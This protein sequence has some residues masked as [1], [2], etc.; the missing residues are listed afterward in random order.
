MLEGRS[1]GPGVALVLADRNKAVNVAMDLAHGITVDD[2]ARWARQAEERAAAEAAKPPCAKCK[3]AKGGQ[4]KT[5]KV[6][7]G[8]SYR[9]YERKGTQWDAGY[10]DGKNAALMGTATSVDATG[11]TELE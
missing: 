3:A 4:C 2:R 11:R 6:T 8:R 7:G 5:H 9:Y 10:T 1:S